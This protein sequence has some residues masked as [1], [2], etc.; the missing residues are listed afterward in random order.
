MSAAYRG[1]LL[2]ATILDG[3]RNIFPIAFAVVDN[4]NDDAW[5]FFFKEL[6]VVVE[7]EPDLIFVSDRH[8]SIANGLRNNYVFAK[9]GYCTFHLYQNFKT[10]YK[11]GDLFSLFNKAAKAYT[12]QNFNQLF[13][14]LRRE[15]PKVADYLQMAGFENWSRAHF[16]ANRFS[17]MTSNN[18]ETMNSTFKEERKWPIVAMFE[19]I[20]ETIAK[21]FCERREKAEKWGQLV[22]KAVHDNLDASYLRSLTMSVRRLSQFE[23]EVRD[24]TTRFAVNMHSR[25]CDCKRFQ[26]DQIP[27]AHAIA[28]ATDRGVK[29]AEL[30]SPMF[31]TERLKEVYKETIHLVPPFDRWVVP[32]VVGSITCLPPVVK[33]QPGRRK[34][35][36]FKAGWEKDWSKMRKCGRCGVRGHNQ[37]NCKRPGTSASMS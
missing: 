14:Q 28:A 3:N 2:L 21:W 4:E 13:E 18:A 17:I 26:I 34:T 9:H 6:R 7:D 29:Y 23:A 19:A 30:V 1:T 31:H 8:P 12:R 15:S 25:T 27:C 35:N 36:R 16:C 20:L 33:N 10:K 22:T 5:S 24:G 11:R 32:P 37:R